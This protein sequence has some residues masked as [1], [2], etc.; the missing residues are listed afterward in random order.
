MIVKTRKELK[1]KMFQ[2]QYEKFIQ[3]K[4]KQENL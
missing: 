2:I 4:Q 3:E 1:N